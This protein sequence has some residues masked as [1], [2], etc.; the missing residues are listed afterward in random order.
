MPEYGVI[1]M[2]GEMRE[3]YDLEESSHRELADRLVDMNID[4]I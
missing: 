1:C 4:Y 2:M 3:L